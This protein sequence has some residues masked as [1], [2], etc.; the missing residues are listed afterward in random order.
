MNKEKK[1]E[2]VTI[3]II[4]G[5]VFGIISGA[6]STISLYYGTDCSGLVKSLV[7]PA[8]ALGV[9]GMIGLCFILTDV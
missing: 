1:L 3:M 8:I 9:P 2:T 6:A 5:V 7:I 4:V